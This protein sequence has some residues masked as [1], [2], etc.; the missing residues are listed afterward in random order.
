MRKLIVA[1]V[2]VAVLTSTGVY[3]DQTQAT[4]AVSTPSAAANQLNTTNPCASNHV[5]PC[6]AINNSPSCGAGSLGCNP[7]TA[8]MPC[9]PCNPCAAT[10]PSAANNCNACNPAAANSCNPCNPSSSN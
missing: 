5:T 1:T 3:A 2:A 8:T 4:A 6:S 7:C 9:A 10:N